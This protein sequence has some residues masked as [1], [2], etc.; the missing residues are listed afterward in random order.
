MLSRS[1]AT[2]MAWRWRRTRSVRQSLAVSTAPFRRFPLA[3]L[4]RSSKRS[5]RARA[6]AT[7]PA[8]PTRTP[9]PTSS[10]RTFTAPR[11]STVWPKVTWPSPARA[12]TP[13]LRTARMVV[14]CQ[15]GGE[16]GIS[17]MGRG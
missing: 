1:A 10:F 15:D 3:S 17:F 9:S 4:S 11:L 8:N 12:V 16:E 2:I 5:R 6:S 13:S 14:P 7:P